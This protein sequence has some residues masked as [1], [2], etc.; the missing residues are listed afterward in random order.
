M[1]QGPSARAGVEEG[2]ATKRTC[3][4]ADAGGS[5]GGLRAQART[6][7]V[8]QFVLLSEVGIYVH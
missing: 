1:R 7:S 5:S 3:R 2:R 6:G 4:W 8:P